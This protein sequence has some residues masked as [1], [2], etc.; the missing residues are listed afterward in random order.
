MLKL[1]KPFTGY[2]LRARTNPMLYGYDRLYRP[3]FESF[4]QTQTPYN[5]RSL[6]YDRSNQ[7]RKF[8]KIPKMLTTCAKKTINRKRKRTLVETTPASKIDLKLPDNEVM[9]IDDVIVIHNDYDI[10]TELW[11]DFNEIEYIEG[12]DYDGDVWIS[13][14]ALKSY[15]MDDP[16]LD[17]VKFHRNRLPGEVQAS[18]SVGT[19]EKGPGGSILFEMGNKFEKNVEEYIYAHYP[20]HVRKICHTYQDVYNKNK[21]ELTKKCILDGVPI[22]LQGVLHNNMNKT[23]GSPDI[24]IRSDYLSI[25]FDRP[26]MTQDEM[27]YK[28]PL[29]KGNYHYV[30]IDIKW[31]TMYLC[32]DAYHLRKMNMFPAYKGQLAVYTAALGHIQGYTPSK[33]FIMAKSWK[34]EKC[35]IQYHGYN[36]FDTLGVIDY[37]ERDS[38]YLDYSKEAMNWIRDVKFNG[39]DWENYPNPERLEMYPNMCNSYDMPYGTLKRSYANA[40]KEHTMIWNVG[41]LNRVLALQ[42]GIMTYDDP[43]NCA[44]ALGIKGEKKGPII[45]SIININKENEDRIITPDVI[46]NTLYDWQDD[47]C[48]ELFCDFETMNTDFYTKNI[49]LTNSQSISN[50]LF[51]IGIGYCQAG[52]WIYKHFTMNEA[53]LEEEER[54][55]DEFLDYIDEIKNDFVEYYGTEIPDTVIPK[56]FHWTHAEISIMRAVNARHQHKWT[57]RISEQNIM[58]AD[59]HKV[60]EDEPIAIKG[61]MGHRLKDIVNAMKCHGLINVSWPSDGPSNGF[62]AMQWASAYYEKKDKLDAEIDDIKRTQVYAIRYARVKEL[63]DG[64]IRYNDIDCKSLMEIVTYFRYAHGSEHLAIHNQLLDDPDEFL[65]PEAV[66]VN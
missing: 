30:I 48:L 16:F 13:A 42:Q 6:Q 29:L 2:D 25:L 31:T 61:V 62:A 64:I 22:I 7:T 36:C 44:A 41:P 3:I 53:T 34:Y 66:E 40:I 19:G 28:A 21:I 4:R 38:Q 20:L 59:F 63:I 65:V 15:L 47:N 32:A 35:K 56:V 46:G 50:L 33:A 58:W 57:E 54:V 23:F 27:E 39:A 60:Y 49:N 55:V 26:Q 37:A 52:N 1:R 24:I 43:R 51:M 18:Y 10:N 45:D 11:S 5:L 14:T 9:N 12:V 17:Y 8:I